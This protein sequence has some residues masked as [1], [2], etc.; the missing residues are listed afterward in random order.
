MIKQLSQ[1]IAA[2]FVTPRLTGNIEDPCSSV[3][4]WRDECHSI[5]EDP[6]GA[7]PL[8]W[9]VGDRANRQAAASSVRDATRR[10]TPHNLEILKFHKVG[11]SMAGHQRARNTARALWFWVA[12]VPTACHTIPEVAVSLGVTKSA[13]I[14]WESWLIIFYTWA[15]AKLTIFWKKNQNHVN[16][17]VHQKKTKLYRGIRSESE[18]AAG[19]VPGS[20]RGR[21]ERS[22]TWVGNSTWVL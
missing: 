20:P 11:T 21:G 19:R 18:P 14:F 13:A 8:W 5:S 12:I 2:D 9:P 17:N 15:V 1:N 22:R 4:C 7:G 10:R 16:N 3:G 6:G